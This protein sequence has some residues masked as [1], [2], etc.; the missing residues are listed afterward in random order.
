[1]T[2]ERSGFGL[3]AVCT[4]LPVVLLSYIS[5]RL[6]IKK[7]IF[8]SLGDEFFVVCGLI[9]LGLLLLSNLELMHL[10]A[11]PVGLSFDVT[12]EAVI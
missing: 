12:V 7:I 3:L 2:C 5:L 6:C 9:W 11:I 4:R 1:M 8:L 10:L